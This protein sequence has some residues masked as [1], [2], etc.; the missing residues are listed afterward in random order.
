[1]KVLP[2][3]MGAMR[4]V[5]ESIVVM[6]NQRRKSHESRRPRPGAVLCYWISGDA[7]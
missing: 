5:F 4:H 6:Q 1:M 7:A 2:K 3:I